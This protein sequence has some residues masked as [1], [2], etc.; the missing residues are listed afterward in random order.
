VVLA[1]SSFLVA[2][3][4]AFAETTDFNA[5]VQATIKRPDGPCADGARRCGDALLA[6]F[7]PAEWRFYLASFQPISQSC[8]SYTAIVTFTLEDESQLTLDEAGIVCGPGKSFFATPNFSWGNPDEV[9]ASWEVQGATG[10]FAGMIGSGT[11]TGR[12]AGAHVTATY[13]GTL[14]G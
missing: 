12:S 3:S 7:G 1:G 4:A 9:A 10:Q 14:E 13:T 11:D 8:G 2:P 6:G 5:D